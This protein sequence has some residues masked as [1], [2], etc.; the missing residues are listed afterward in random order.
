MKDLSRYILNGSTLRLYVEKCIGCG[1]CVDVCPHAV[2]E[3]SG[4]KAVVLRRPSCMECGACKTNCPVNAIEV[5]SGVGC[6]AA[7]ILGALTNSEPSCGCS[8]DGKGSS[9]C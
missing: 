6:A 8:E 3:L 2:F 4:K 1:M 5:R 7:I 9:C